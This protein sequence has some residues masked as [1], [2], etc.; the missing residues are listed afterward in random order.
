MLY[1]GMEN[2]EE[3]NRLLANSI[4][5]TM[6][7]HIVFSMSL[8]SA[9][10][11][12]GKLQTG[13][14][15]LDRSLV[16]EPSYPSPPRYALLVFGRDAKKQIM[17]VQC[18][19]ILYVDRNGNR[20]LTEKSERIVG[21]RNTVGRSGRQRHRIVFRVG[22]IVGANKEKLGF[23]YE[24][25]RDRSLGDFFH[26]YKN[27]QPKPY[28]HGQRLQGLPGDSRGEF[29]LSSKR[30]TCPVYH[31]QGPLTM[32]RIGNDSFI[33]GQMDENLAI[34]IGTPGIGQGSFAAVET[35]NVP[36]DVHPKAV[37]VF[38][39]RLNPKTPIRLTLILKKRC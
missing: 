18:G 32:R 34:R 12:E 30:E 37:L 9:A 7:W 13:P 14:G 25:Y 21:T 27:F 8:L 35:D 4:G 3:L 38:Q 31:F 39:N 26:L 2:E 1:N 10:A 15:E 24:H 22:D 23:V 28:A 6:A 19:S 17:V 33:A 36:K 29:E 20:D 16:R 11:S 5:E